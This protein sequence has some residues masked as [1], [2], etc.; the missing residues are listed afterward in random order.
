MQ[1]VLT[2]IRCFS[3]LI[4]VLIPLRELAQPLFNRRRRLEVKVALQ[5][6]HIRVRL[7][8]IARLHWQEL[9]L[10]R[11]ADG[12]FQHLNE[13]HE[14]LRLVVADVVD[15]VAVAELI[16][17][18]RIA[19]HVLDA[20]D[21]VIDIGEV[22]VH[23]AVVVN[24]DGLA[25]ADLVSELEIRHIRTA[26]R[27]VDREEAQPRRRNPIEMAVSVRHELIRLLR[28][29]IEADRMVD[30]VRRRERRLLLIAIDRRARS[31]EQMLHLMMTTCLE[32]VEEADD[33]RVDIRARM[34][35]AVP[36]TSLRREI[37][38]N[39]RL[40]LIEQRRDCR[41]IRQVTLD[42]RERR[43][44]AQDLQP[45]LLQADIIV[46]IDIIKADNRRPEPQQPLRQMKA[47]KSRSTGD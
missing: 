13:V 17:L 47:D 9:L 3:F 35:D 8:D 2:R 26:E 11:L 23:I 31:K 36:H 43:I 22:A 20:R 1:T 34:V 5:F 24:L 4:V 14:L 38:D 28:R 30:I 10:C 18:R 27:S 44:L 6:A 45:A 19:E 33:V 42:K 15:L 40:I 7:I 16:R 12:L 41:L 46:I 37:D 29:R 32:N 39:V 21:D 25:P